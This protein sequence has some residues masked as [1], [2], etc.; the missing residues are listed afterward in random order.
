MDTGVSAQSRIVNETDAL[1]T[2]EQ[3]QALGCL[4]AGIRFCIRLNPPD[5][6]PTVTN[7]HCKSMHEELGD[8]LKHHGLTPQEDAPIIITLASTACKMETTPAA[9]HKIYIVLDDRPLFEQDLLPAERTRLAMQLALWQGAGHVISDPMSRQ[10]SDEDL[11]LAAQRRL[12]HASNRIRKLNVAGLLLATHRKL[13]E[14]GH[15]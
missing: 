11:R 12:V 9:R 2:L 10:V 3:R 6:E 5:E 8:M 15:H 4:C 14:L 1:S 13:E 7:L